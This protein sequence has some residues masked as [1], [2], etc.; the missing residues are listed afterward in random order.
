MGTKIKNVQVRFPDELHKTLELIAE[1]EHTTLADIMRKGL[2]LYGIIRAY[3]KEGKQVALVD[4]SGNVV[5]HLVI[6]GITTP[7]PVIASSNT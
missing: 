5:A 3:R 4:E 2:Q 7:E 6:P 1:E